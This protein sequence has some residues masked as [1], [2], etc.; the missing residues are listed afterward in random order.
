[1]KRSAREFRTVRRDDWIM[2]DVDDKALMNRN[3]FRPKAVIQRREIQ[4]LKEPMEGTA[5]SKPVISKE[6]L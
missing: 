4:K 3:R 1:M 2:R 5:V 6:F